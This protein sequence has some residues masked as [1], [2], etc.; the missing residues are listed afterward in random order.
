[1]TTSTVIH[2]SIDVITTSQWEKLLDTDT[3]NFFQTPKALNFFM[4]VGWETFTFA[5]ENE[6]EINVLI[7]G[8]IQKEKGL[9]SVISSRAIIYGGPVIAKTATANDLTDVLKELIHYLQKK[10]IYIETRNF[11]DYETWKST[12]KKSGFEYHPH[13]NFHVDCSEETRM[14]K[15]MSS[16]KV[17]QVKKSLKAGAEIVEA[18]TRTEVEAYYAILENLYKTKVKTPLPDVSFFVKMWE[19]QAAK[20]LLVSYQNQV[21]GGIICPVLTNKVI[22][23]WYVCGKDGM[24]KN[25]YPSIL[26]TWAAMDYAVKHNIPRFDFMGAGK[27]DQ[28]YGVREFKS[29]FGGKQ[30]AH[31][32]FLK[33]TKPLLYKIGKKAVEI[34]KNS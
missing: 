19:T 2:K 11:N 9:K 14:R 4:T 22:Y 15:Q 34:L 30:V 26:A 10:V 1:M 20:F 29:K 12:F 7:S 17:R 8:I 18:T 31:G 16:S 23:E 28:D 27:P 24:Y 5:S 6:G 33:V 13:L 25:I 3:I 32:R 21:I